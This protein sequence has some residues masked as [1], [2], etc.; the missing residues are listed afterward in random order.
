MQ[1]TPNAVA[2]VFEQGHLTYQGTQ[3]AS[4]SPG[5]SSA[6]ARRG[7]RCIGGA[8]MERLGGDAGVYP[9][10][11]KAGGAYVPLDP[12]WPSERLAF[13]L[14]DSQVPVLLTQQSLLSRRW[15]LRGCC[16]DAKGKSYSQQ[17]LQTPRVGSRISI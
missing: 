12:D 8:C 9:G 13:V 11:L 16:V 2:V 4:Q 17:A 15:P 7:T 10:C 14:D 1:R 6:R 5:P 3:R